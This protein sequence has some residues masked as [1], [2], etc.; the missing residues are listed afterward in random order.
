MRRRKS[1]GGGKVGEEMGAERRRVRCEELGGMKALERQV[2]VKREG[3][4]ILS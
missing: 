3:R 1:W 2:G 4:E